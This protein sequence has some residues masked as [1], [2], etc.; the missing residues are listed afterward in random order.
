MGRYF[1]ECLGG[2]IIFSCVKCDTF[3]TNL[4]SLNS[5]KF[6]GKFKFKIKIFYL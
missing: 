1:F 4:E 3:L 5:D 2:K 6:R